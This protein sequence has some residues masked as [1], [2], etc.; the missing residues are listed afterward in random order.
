MLS[1]VPDE[2]GRTF[3]RAKYFQLAIGETMPVKDLQVL[4]AALNPLESSSIN[5]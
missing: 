2:T 4:S 3:L 5:F 1:H